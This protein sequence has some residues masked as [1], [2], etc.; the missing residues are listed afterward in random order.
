MLSLSNYMTPNAVNPYDGKTAAFV[1][2]K[3]STGQVLLSAGTVTDS[4][5][6][7]SYS[8]V[9]IIGYYLDGGTEVSRTKVVALD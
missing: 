9:N 8:G 1:T 5:T 7:M 2:T 6:G 4:A 3:T